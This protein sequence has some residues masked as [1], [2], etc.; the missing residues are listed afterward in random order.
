MPT[1]VIRYPDGTEHEH[2]V[3]TQLTIGRSEGNDLILTEGGVSRKHARFFVEGSALQVEDVGSAN[4]TWVDGARIEQAT[5]VGAKSQVV[6]GDYEISVKVGSKGAAK[7]PAGV[8]PTAEKPSRE[9]TAAVGKP[10]KAVS[11]R[12]TKVVP[13][14]KPA[15][16][17]G[18]LA[19]RAAPGRASGPQ[20]KGLTGS[21]T[22]KTF[23][24]SGT[25]TVGRVAGTDITVDDDSVSRKHAEVEVRGRDVVVRD[26]GSANGTTVNGAPISEET[27]LSAGDILQFGVV[28]L[29]FETGAAE[30]A[31]ASGRLPARRPTSAP[32]RR[33][34]PLDDDEAPV[35]P[36]IDA[37]MSPGRKRMLVGAGLVITALFAVVL[38]KAFTAPAEDIPPTVRL[39]PK[40][41]A[42][43][44]EDQ[45]D[46]LLTECRT[47]S[48]PEIGKPDWARAESACKKVIELDPIQADANQLL[49][50]IEI[51]RA[52]EQNLDKGRAFASTGRLEDALDSLAKVGVKEGECPIYALRALSESKNPMAEV[53]KASA[54]ECKDYATNAKWDNAFRRCELYMRL[55]CQMMD[56]KDLY[57]PPLTKLKLDG[58]I[59]KG[60]W[61][62]SDPLYINFLKAREKVKPGEPPWQC[63]KIYA[64]RPPPP[65]PD[66]KRLAREE[67]AKRFPDPDMGEALIRYF[68][69]R[70]DARVPLQRIREN[71]NRAG[72]HDQA[73]ALQADIDTAQNL[74]QTGVGEL[75]REAPERAEAPFRAALVVDSKLVLGDRDATLSEDEKRKELEKRSSFIR[76]TII[77]T[78]ASACY[79][80]GKTLADRKDFRQACKLWKL[81]ASFSRGNIDLLKALTNVCTRRAQDTLARA[82]NCEQLKQVLDF[83][84]DGDGLKKQAEG[85]MGEFGCEAPAQ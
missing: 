32:T 15:N 16:G 45:I 79:E 5:P 21:I 61:R 14:I 42:A 48:T 30:P 19:K 75:A 41:P 9:A 24:L 84:V 70:S 10:V 31:A 66:P 49:R 77:E 73:R 36:P 55:S 80:R 40:V 85:K 28:E 1:L 4:G 20:L 78:M 67:F 3:T 25:M 54:R 74:Y 71:M 34:R 72:E 29:M 64:F 7:R 2:A 12:S 68:D 18:A 59:G 27:P 76:K 58:P 65:P 82:E 52:C 81:G 50:K 47:Y 13:S 43:T 62:P 17:S 26:L 46:G 56:D 69:N 63:P 60:D 51:E 8:G 57:P 33:P 6:I 53:R 44:A 11:P 39:D 23:A 22:G 83:A 35:A 37:P 38:A